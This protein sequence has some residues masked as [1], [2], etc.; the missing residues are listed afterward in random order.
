MEKKN[1]TSSRFNENVELRQYYY[2]ERI[3]KDDKVTRKKFMRYKAG[4]EMDI[5]V[6]CTACPKLFKKNAEIIPHIFEHI[7]ADE[8]GCFVIRERKH[9]LRHSNL[10]CYICMKKT[11]MDSIAVHVKNSHEMKNHTFTCRICELY[12]D[13]KKELV[14]HMHYTHPCLDM[15]YSCDICGYRS[16]FRTSLF[17]HFEESHQKNFVMCNFCLMIIPVESVP[18][19]KF[20]ESHLMQHVLNGQSKCNQCALRFTSQLELQEHTKEKHQRHADHTKIE[21][22]KLYKLSKGEEPILMWIPLNKNPRRQLDPSGLLPS[23]NGPQVRRTKSDESDSDEELEVVYEKYSTAV[24]TETIG[25]SYSHSAS[26]AEPSSSSS[27]SSNENMA[28]KPSNGLISRSEGKC[29]PSGFLKALG[30]RRVR[31]S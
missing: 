28:S 4:S 2:G 18:D 26:D 3:P 16:S 11:T 29:V 23:N 14:S 17:K 7:E 20:L 24:G 25:S 30:L 6:K 5:H 22:L 21:E 19:M 15:P 13:T 27:T 12:Y 9:P 31:M 10:R 1:I 8:S